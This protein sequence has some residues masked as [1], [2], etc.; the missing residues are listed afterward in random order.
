LPFVRTF[1]KRFGF[2]TALL[3]IAA[4]ADFAFEQTARPAPPK[5]GG[6]VMRIY[7]PVTA[8]TNIERA[9][10]RQAALMRRDMPATRGHV[11]VMQPAYTETVTGRLH[12]ELLF[13]H[14]LFDY[15][16]L[17]LCPLSKYR[18]AAK[19]DWSTEL[20]GIGVDDSVFWKRLEKSAGAYRSV[21]CVGPGVT[22]PGHPLT[23]VRVKNL[24]GDGEVQILVDLQQCRRRFAAIQSAQNSIGNATLDKVLYSVVAPVT[25][26]STSTSE[27]NYIEKLLY[28]EEGCK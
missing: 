23:S 12:P 27:G 28:L 18:D 14:E 11:R 19:R 8:L 16:V 20:R 25:N 17:V 15:L 7:P 1:P 5:P 9:L 4:P 21:H 24:R 3:L 13:R 26:F 2:I 6:V 22:R 10:R